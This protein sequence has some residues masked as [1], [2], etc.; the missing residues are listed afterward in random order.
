MS[1]GRSSRRSFH[2][3]RWPD[4]CRLR[5]EGLKGF[6][7][8]TMDAEFLQKLLA[9]FKIEA[10]EHLNVMAT[11]LG[12]LEKGNAWSQA[13]I[14]ET[15]YRETH[16]LKGAARSVNLADIVSLCQSMETVFLALKER[17]IASSVQAVDLLLQA[18]DLCYE[19]VDGEKSTAA[20]RSAVEKLIRQLDGAAMGK[21]IEE[22]G[23]PSAVEQAG[24]PAKQTDAPG[25]NPVA[26]HPEPQPLEAI[27]IP[28]GP[29]TVRVSR[30]SLISLLLQAEEML[31]FKLAGSQRLAELR[32]LKK[33]FDSWKN[34]R[35]KDG[36]RRSGGGAPSAEPLRLD[37]FLP[38]FGS[39]LTALVRETEKDY[40]LSTALIDR[41]FDDMKKTLMFPFS[42]MLGL[43]PR[44]VRDLART[45]GKQV[46]LTV[47]GGEIEIGGLILEE[48]KAPL[49]HL[50]RNCIDHGIEAP[51]ERKKKNKPASGNIKIG[52]SSRDGKVEIE[53]RDDGRGIDVAKIRTSAVT[54]MGICR[55]E[56]D[57]LGAQE[58][59]QLVFQS[60]MTTSPLLTD[61]SGRGL[62]LAIVKEKVEK[63]N[64]TV[65]VETRLDAGTTFH[66]VVPLTLARF[67]GTL[68]RVSEQVVVLPSTHVERVARVNKEAIQT[69]ENRETL[70][71]EGQ[72]VSF[73][74]LDDVLELKAAGKRRQS[75]DAQ[76]QVVVVGLAETNMALGVDEVVCEQE[77]LVK[78]LGKQLA[79]VRNIM[80]ATVLGNGKV[81]PVLNMSDLFRT[82]LRTVPSPTG[83]PVEEPGESSSVLVVEDS[84]TARMLLKN[85]LE[86]AG[87]SVQTAVDGVDAM[88]ALKVRDF[89]VV[90]SD[91]EM[92][93]MNGFELTASIRSEK[94]FSRL[95]VVLV[96]ALE[97]REDRER[98]IDV[99]ANA[100]IVKSSF[101]QSNL[102]E[103]IDRL[104]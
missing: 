53:I 20:A 19:L 72:P 38:S 71:L 14:V 32:D 84:I 51:E 24:G 42:S 52:I 89:D 69:V 31:S 70:I 78:P 43:F 67:R 65:R 104:T 92:P 49:I 62:G 23:R 93:R 54:N 81:V 40:R 21:E 30:T 100:Y 66:L 12:K 34:G 27:S 17:R 74:R 103:V 60:G 46:E 61:I 56:M 75:D 8:E 97:S 83:A 77:I 35:Q 5:D 28:V 7:M 6:A 79:R 44:L 45:A 9:M 25:K 90:V 29:E 68:V 98:G 102:L 85:I 59:L 37:P 3:S 58:A 13:D 82:A 47:E 101:D 99:G 95:P 73:A 94:K 48:M 26:Y 87:Y 4:A 91:V 57:R 33:E 63:L 39:R 76:V 11:E 80:G 2:D 15:I 96:T 55:E 18:V 64:G 10:R 1:W 88:A 22:S 41:L 36:I 16:T 86:S 50:V